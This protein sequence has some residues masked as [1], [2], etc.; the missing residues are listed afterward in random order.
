M[1]KIFLIILLV[2][3][4]LPSF[5]FARS[6]SI[7]N[8]SIDYVINTDGQVN[9]S[10]KLTYT[11]EGCY[12]ELYLQRPTSLQIL[13]ASGSCDGKECFFRHDQKDTPSGD[14]ELV[15][16]SNYCDETINVSFSYDIVNVI[17]QLQDGIFQFYYQLYGKETDYSTNL[18]I[19][20]TIPNSFDNT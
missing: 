8:Y 16:K 6:L 1:R 9:V 4:L 17:N 15:L 12:T 7:D 3:L 20:L 5:T 18:N 14:Q 10:E 2:V 13:N 11:L 19:S